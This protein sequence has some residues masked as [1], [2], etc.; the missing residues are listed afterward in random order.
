MSQKD[1]GGQAIA[2]LTVRDYFA[3]NAPAQRTD[4][5]EHGAAALV[6][7]EMP[8]GPGEECD[9]QARIDY[10]IAKAQFHIDLDVALRLR[11]ADAMLKARKS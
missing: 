9:E 3:M 5:T 2:N 4:F 11:W 10:Q 7:R 8:S 1:N 6:G